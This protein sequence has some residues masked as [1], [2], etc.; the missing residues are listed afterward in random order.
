MLHAGN[1]SVAKGDDAVDD[2]AVP[3]RER[4]G[5]LFVGEAHPAG[6][7]PQRLSQ[8]HKFL[9]VVADFLFGVLALRPGHHEVV[10]HS[11]ELAILPHAGREGLGL[12]QHQLDIQSGIGIDAFHFGLQGPDL[13]HLD[14]LVGVFPHGMPCLDCVYEFHCL[15]YILL[16]SFAGTPPTTVLASTSF[17]TTAPAATTAPSP[18]V[19]P[20][21]TVALAPIHTFLPI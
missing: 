15:D 2:I 12:I 3:Q 13:C 7:E 1:G 9:A 17:V 21:R 14:G 20:G 4:S 5:N 6:V 16:I 8:K 19:T 11:G 18:M 10:S